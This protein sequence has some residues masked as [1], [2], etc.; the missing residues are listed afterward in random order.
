[1]PAAIT[2][3]RNVRAGKLLVGNTPYALT[4]LCEHHVHAIRLAALQWAWSIPSW[5]SSIGSSRSGGGM[6]AETTGV[7]SHG[8]SRRAGVQHGTH[9]HTVTSSSAF[10]HAR[11]LRLPFQSSH[12]PNISISTRSH[13][14]VTNSKLKTPLRPMF[15]GGFIAPPSS[16][17]M[18]P[19]PCMKLYVRRAA[20]ALFLNTFWLIN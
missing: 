14:Q 15:S 10:D 20:F 5:S 8:T 13:D 17:T 16:F 9:P 3:I 18:K 1:M 4:P 6:D 11:K 12:T 19:V 2:T 7:S